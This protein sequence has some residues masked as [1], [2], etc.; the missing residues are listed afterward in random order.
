[1]Y[2][3]SIRRWGFSFM[4]RFGFVFGTSMAFYNSTARLHGLTNNGLKW[5]Y[6]LRP[7]KK[8]DFSSEHEKGTIWQY[9]RN[10]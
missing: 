5:R 3:N 2:R 1:M 4:T 9:F 7:I 8:Y 6:D 10:K